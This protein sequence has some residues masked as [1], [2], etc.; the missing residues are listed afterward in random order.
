MMLMAGTFSSSLPAFNT[1]GPFLVQE[2]LHLS[3]LDYG[4]IALLLGGSW[5]LG[6]LTSRLLFDLSKTK[7]TVGCFFASLVSVA[8]AIAI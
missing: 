7:K 1:I 8:V 5:F 4:R 3:A 2:V 6:N